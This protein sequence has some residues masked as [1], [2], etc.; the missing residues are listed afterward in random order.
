MP[1]K[2]D[3]AS[4]LFYSIR[5][6]NIRKEDLVKAVFI[7]EVEII[8]QALESGLHAQFPSS[9]PYFSSTCSPEEFEIRGY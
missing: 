3:Q 8:M 5:K 7:Q 1:H 6:K 9:P 4:D 2:S